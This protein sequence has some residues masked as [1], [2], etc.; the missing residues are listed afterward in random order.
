MPDGRRLNRPVNALNTVKYLADCQLISDQ[1]RKRDLRQRVLYDLVQANDYRP[2]P[3]V[4][5]MY[6]DL[7]DARVAFAVLAEDV[8]VEDLDDLA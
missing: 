8:L 3:A 7:K 5:F 4:A 6:A 2:Y 1:L